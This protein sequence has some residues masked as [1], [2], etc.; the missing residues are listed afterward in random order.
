MGAEIPFAS[1]SH[2]KYIA[3]HLSYRFCG[4]AGEFCQNSYFKASIEKCIPCSI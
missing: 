1:F 4:Q 3:F 2:Y